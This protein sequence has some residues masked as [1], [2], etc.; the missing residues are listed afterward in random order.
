MST[1]LLGLTIDS[2]YFYLFNNNRE[3]IFDN[4]SDLEEL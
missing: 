1:S 2:Y 4:T 3:L